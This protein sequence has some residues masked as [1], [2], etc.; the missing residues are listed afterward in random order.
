MPLTLRD[1]LLSARRGGFVLR[2]PFRRHARSTG[3]T[4]DMAL[5]VAAW[6]RREGFAPGDRAIL[7]GDSGPDNV[8]AFLGCILQGVVV[9]PLED[10]AGPDFAARVQREAQATIAFVGRAAA[11]HGE[12][13][14]PAR[15]VALDDLAHVLD[16]VAPSSVDDLPSLDDTALLEIVFTSGTTSEPKGVL[17]T[18]RNLVAVLAALEGPY[19]KWNAR[20]GWLVRRRPVVVLVP[21]SHMFGQVV[22]V[23]VPLMMGLT[24]VFVA[25]PGPSAIRDALRQ[26]RAWAMLTVPR[27]LGSL[28]R[29]LEDELEL[30]KERLDARERDAD[31]PL[32]RRMLRWR[33]VRRRLGLRFS[34][35]VVG[36]AALDAE[37][38]I[39]WRGMGYLIAQGYGLTETA[40]IVTLSNPFGKAR[41][42]VGKPLH[43]QEIE[44]SPEGE[45]LVRGENV[46]AGYLTGGQVHGVVDAEGWLHTGDLGELDEAGRLRIVGRSKDVVVTAEGLNVY[47]RDVEVVLSRDARVRDAAVVGVRRE[48]GDEVHAV[49]LLSAEARDDAQ[50]DARD[51]VASANAQLP[52]FQR[53]RGFTVWTGADFPRTAA[54]GKVKKRELIAA[55]AG[56]PAGVAAEGL[57]GALKAMAA[58]G[59]DT[60]R[61]S[62]LG[63]SSLETVDLVSRLEGEL[64]VVIDETR[65]RP[66]M[67]LGEL[68]ALVAS[69]S[70]APAPVRVTMPRWRRSWWAGALGAL[71]RGTLAY[72]PLWWSQRPLRV[73]GREHLEGLDGPVMFVGNHVSYLDAPTFFRALPRRMRG[74]IATA[75]ATEPFHP[76]FT[77]EGTRGQRAVQ[78][79]RYVLT[80]LAFGAFPLPRSSGFRASLE[81]AG[82]MVDHGWSV[83]LYPEGSMSKD[84]AMHAFRGGAGL[85]ARE[86]RIPVVP[87]RTRG[88]WEVMPPAQGWH[89]TPGSVTFTFGAP[90]R[91]DASAS[92]EERVKAMEAAVRGL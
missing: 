20:I 53:I 62:E 70:D 35:F 73:E 21:L 40:P 86:L 9:V 47:A 58:G 29:Q 2:T 87:F 42:R 52:A 60:T 8:A 28:R 39:A 22:G 46:T 44:L 78:R 91:F 63:L 84:G 26:E 37:D 54:T 25:P 36:G 15:L 66:D 51:I 31:A 11:R 55:I 30:P 49:L 74:R 88:L 4:R 65:V 27:F 56:A 10:A 18:H 89:P 76:L 41:G 64:Q 48:G 69:P 82:E 90:L 3:D 1:L 17:L 33:D 7:W 85:L 79:L 81:Y 5:R 45:V 59:A 16:R 12:A 61:L 77:R 24:A 92:A 75:M 23:F 43:G 14:A 72:P 38:E 34:A 6:L 19:R 13:L 50:D 32:W 80:V 57:D 68:K 83:L 71:L 67:T